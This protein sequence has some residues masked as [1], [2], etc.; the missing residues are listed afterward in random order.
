[1]I[2]L[3]DEFI[4]SSERNRPSGE[5]ANWVALLKHGDPAEQRRAVEELIALNAQ[6]ELTGCLHCKDSNVVLLATAGL[7]ECWLNERGE[8][9]R[10]MMDEGVELMNAGHLAAAAKIFLGLI[11]KFPDWAEAINKQATLLYVRGEPAES[12]ALCKK[13]VALKPH[14]FGAWNGMALCGVQLEDWQTALAAA[15]RALEIQ[16]TAESNLEIVRLA[17]IKLSGE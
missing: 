6:A 5:I 8:S 13:V 2:R 12:L 7:W 9:A 15:E 10:Q 4:P 3:N 14:H 17:K 1:M 16:P 11:K